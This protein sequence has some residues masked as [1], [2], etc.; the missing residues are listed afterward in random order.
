MTKCFHLR[1]YCG[2]KNIFIPGFLTEKTEKSI[3]HREMTI[4]TSSTSSSSSYNTAS[5]SVVFMSGKTSVISAPLHFPMNRCL[6]MRMKM[7]QF[8][9]KHSSIELAVHML[10]MLSYTSVPNWKI[11]VEIKCACCRVCAVC[12]V[13]DVDT[14]IHIHTSILCTVSRAHSMHWV[15]DLCA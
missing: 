11:N 14:L 9:G 5:R 10:H 3:L 1:V 13:Y 7:N 12:R 6:M 4:A 15:C 2:W 8:S